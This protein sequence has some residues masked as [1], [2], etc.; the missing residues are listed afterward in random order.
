M[1][2]LLQLLLASSPPRA[3]VAR[4]APT[5]ARSADCMAER[6]T[7]PMT[8]ARIKQGDPD[9]RRPKPVA[10]S[11]TPAPVVIAMKTSW[12]MGPSKGGDGRP[13]VRRLGKP[14][15]RPCRSGGSP[16]AGSSVQ[17]LRPRAPGKSDKDAHGQQDNRRLIVKKMQITHMARLA[18]KIKRS[19]FSQP[20][21][22]R[23]I[24]RPR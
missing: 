12:A 14:K 19:G 11:A 18:R 10:I 8:P 15:M 17:P 1:P 22:R 7:S 21:T 13:P 16:V 24:D 6:D 23:R 5:S 3:G 20:A 9:P 4:S 2:P